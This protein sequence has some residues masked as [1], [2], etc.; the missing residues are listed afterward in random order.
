MENIAHTLCGLRIADLGWRERIGPRAPIIGAIAANLPDADLVLMLGG[1]DAYT[2]WHRGI[3]HSVLG[4]PVLALGAAWLSRKVTGEGSYRD[5]LGLWLW[6][7][8]SH[9]LLDWPT[10]WGT[11]L[12][13]PLTDTRFSLDWIF[14]VDPIFWV[15]LGLVPWLLRRG[16]DAGVLPEARRRGARTGLFAL[17]G[18]VLFCGAMRQQAGTHAPEGTRVFPA[19]LAP[20]KWT[21]VHLD[22]ESA[23][24]WLL[25]PDRGEA[26]G[27]WPRL[28]DAERAALEGFVPSERWLWKAKAPAV[29]GR[30]ETAAG[31]V[32]SLTDLGYASWLSGGEGKGRFGAVFILRN[33]GVVER[34]APTSETSGAAAP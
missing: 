34:G 17:A 10:S 16:A 22:G 33:D 1:R 25:Q 20:V 21:G 18:W 15:C 5:H 27:R 9:M 19:P 30:Q 14:I 7:L 24:R 29:A 28:P 4:W 8:C 13:L 12:F 6:G 26:A 3:T 31:T 23:E 11:M 2:W 32:L